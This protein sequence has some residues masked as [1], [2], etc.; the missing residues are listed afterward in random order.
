[1]SV[2]VLN[3]MNAGI[4][5][6]SMIEWH[7]NNNKD[8]FQFVDHEGSVTAS[9]LAKRFS[10]KRQQAASWLSRNAKLGYLVKEETD[11]RR[12]VRD[13][14]P[15]SQYKINPIVS[16]KLERVLNYVFG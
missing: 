5:I 7:V 9:E 1:M 8:Y 15:E 10:I 14:Y 2:S 6:T 13:V 4:A 11:R 16:E 12:W 3:V